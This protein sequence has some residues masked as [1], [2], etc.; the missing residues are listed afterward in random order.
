MSVVG[1]MTTVYILKLVKNKYY[2]GR[3]N[4]PSVRVSSHVNGN[5]AAWTRQYKPIEVVEVIPNCDNYD[6]DKYTI[7]YMS[8]YG[9]GNV[10]GGSF[11]ARK[12]NAS[13]IEQLNR[14]INGSNDRCF[15]CGGSGHFS[16]KCPERQIRCKCYHCNEFGHIA[17]HCPKRRIIWHCEFCYMEFMEKNECVAHQQYCATRNVCYRCGRLGHFAKFCYARMDIRGNHI[18]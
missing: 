18:R 12:L 16:D 8:K 15:I 10:R 3:T 13:A 11:S 7:K 17:K 6:E 2:V 14:M 5:G 4:N 1:K 9:I